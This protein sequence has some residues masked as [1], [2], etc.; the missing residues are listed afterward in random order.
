MLHPNRSLRAIAASCL[1]VTLTS[2]PAHAWHRLPPGT[3][4]WRAAGEP[5]IRGVT[6]GPIESS[7]FAGRGYGTESSAALLDYLARR[8]VNW[9]SIT[10]FGRVFTLEDTRVRMDFEAPY[11]D[12][13][14]AIR[15]MV[16]QAHAR[17]IRV[18][19]IPHLWVDT[20]GW[21]GEMDPGSPE[22]WA[23]YQASYRDFVLAWARD[24]AA[25]GVDAFSIGVECKSWSGR[26]GGYWRGLIADVRAVF[27]GYLT[28]SANWDEAEDVIFWDQLDLIGINAF[29][30]LAD[31]DGASYE[32]YVQGAL[33]ARDS[34][35]ALAGVLEMPVVFVEVGYTTRQ[36]AAVEPW[37]WPDDMEEVVVDE[38]E[39]AR[40]LA[41]S[42]SAF[43]PEPWFAGFFV[44]R[45]YADLDDVSQEAIWG[46]SPHGKRAERVL[47][48]V[49]AQRFGV[50]PDPWGWLRAPAPPPPTLAEVIR[51][52]ERLYTDTVVDRPPP[53]SAPP[54]PP[55]E[56][57]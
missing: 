34:V 35:A 6:V 14:A 52:T 28:Y 23:A 5:G 41:A 33:A 24:A 17:G 22:A 44:W 54:P 55:R 56:V 45:Y 39:Q 49:F 31:H 3:D 57:L 48:R 10:P 21:R 42:L 11:E 16:A 2:A 37:L 20:G 36:N 15:R 51:R 8:G 9:I 50:D 47:E 40:A 32:E 18:L 46:F 1:L 38:R 13:R 53:G 4:G 19:L 7:L 26:F 30:P 43:L 25:T 29:Y 27:D 12:N